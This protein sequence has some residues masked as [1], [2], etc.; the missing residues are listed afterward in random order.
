VVYL[1]AMVLQHESELFKAVGLLKQL[2]AREVYVFGSFARGT[3]GPDSDL[4]LAVRGLPA[5]NY[6]SAVGRLLD[7]LD[8][9][10]DLID[11]EHPPTF[12][13]IVEAW[14]GL[15]RVG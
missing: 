9:G 5:Q 15:K 1:G 7:E 11:L 10:F 6:F 12:M 4:D 3:H 14:G 13:R 8:V 2:G